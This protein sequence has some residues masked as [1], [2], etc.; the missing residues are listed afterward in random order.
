LHEAGEQD[1]A[2]QYFGLTPTAIAEKVLPMHLAGM[3]QR[4][5]EVTA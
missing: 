5:V 2:R 1:Y 4:I 3:A